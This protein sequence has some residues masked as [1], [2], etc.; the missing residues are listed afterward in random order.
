MSD[1]F[2]EVV[3]RNRLLLFLFG[4][5]TLSQCA[6]KVSLFF[7]VVSA[8]TVNEVSLTVGAA[9]LTVSDLLFS[10]PSSA[11]RRSRGVEAVWV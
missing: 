5:S 1:R 2:N 6:A 9:A 10:F 4:P 11:S 8:V 3:F 7:V